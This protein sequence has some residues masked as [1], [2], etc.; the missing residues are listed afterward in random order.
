MDT[1]AIRGEVT[2]VLASLPDHLRAPLRAEGDEVSADMWAPPPTGR[3]T[4]DRGSCPG[5]AT[6]FLDLGPD[7]PLEEARIVIVPEEVRDG[8]GEVYDLYYILS[9]SEGGMELGRYGSLALC[10]AAGEWVADHLPAGL[11]ALLSAA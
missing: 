4:A 5:E 11:R 7:A 8:S 2:R 9:E 3:W 10:G 1:E 6:Y